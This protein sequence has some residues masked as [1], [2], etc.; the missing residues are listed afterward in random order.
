MDLNKIIAETITTS[1][2]GAA[3]HSQ[4]LR[5]TVAGK[6]MLSASTAHKFEEKE[7]NLSDDVLFAS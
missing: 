1:P 2:T 7:Y 4:S 5:L 3:I 6:E